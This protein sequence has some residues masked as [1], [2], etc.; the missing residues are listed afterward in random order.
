MYVFDLFYKTAEVF[1]KSIFVNYLYLDRNHF[2]FTKE[3]F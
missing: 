2:M 3:M 1:N